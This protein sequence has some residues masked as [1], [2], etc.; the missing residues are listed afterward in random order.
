M[1]L[2]LPSVVSEWSTS[3][4][5]DEDS[6]NKQRVDE[7]GDQYVMRME[8]KISFDCAKKLGCGK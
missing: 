1:L 5:D 7:K 2:H 3:H 8:K 6:G 4:D